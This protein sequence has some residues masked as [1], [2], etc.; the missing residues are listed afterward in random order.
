MTQQEQIDA[1]LAQG[2]VITVSS[3]ELTIL[4]KD[5]AGVIIPKIGSV[6]KYN[7]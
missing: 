6:S 4:E 3:D 5:K 1:Y 2:Y 7:K